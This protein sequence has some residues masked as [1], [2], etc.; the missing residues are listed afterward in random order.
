LSSA[1]TVNPAAHE[2]YLK[3]I[4]L[5]KGTAAQKRKA[6]EYFEQAIRLDPNYAP[7]YAG[8][9]SFYWTTLDIPPGQAMPLAKENVLKALSLDPELAQAHSE[10]A[11]I[12]F[13]GDW[14]WSGADKE[15]HRALELNPNDAESHRLY[16]LM[17]SALGRPD[18]ASS[19]IERAED[20]DPLSTSTQI[21]AGFLLY[22]ARRY[23][24]AIDQCRQVLEL[25]ANSPG[26][27]DCLGSAYLAKGM[28]EEALAAAQKAVTL[29]DN[30][31][32]RL[33]G[34][35]RAYALADKRTGAEEVLNE[36]RK[37]SN[38]SYVTP[39]F[40]AVIYAALGERD[41][42]FTWLEKAYAERDA[43]LVWIKVDSE[44]DPLRSDPR[45]QRLLQRMR[46]D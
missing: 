10:L 45:F 30:D 40:S 37:R 17:L 43:Y 38:G 39:Y 11:A 33:V 14:D 26:A 29:S 19:Q 15:F 42:A 20:L 24:A 12:E 31:P 35:G 27:Y 7:A 25:D 4:Y 9:A 44:V 6:K 13:E 8:L 3:G 34:L 21:T 22:Y 18:E 32:Q 28:Y 36:L 23:D 2:A 5:N 46:L 1:P 41:A 16:S